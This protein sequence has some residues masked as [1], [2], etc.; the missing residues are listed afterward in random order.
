MLFRSGLGAIE[1]VAREF[2]DRSGLRWIGGCA[3]AIGFIGLC[4][5]WPVAAAVTASP[6]VSIGVI[7]GVVLVVGWPLMAIGKRL[8]TVAARLCLYSGGLARIDRRAA[9]PVVLRWADVETV[10]IETGDDEGTPTTYLTGCTLRGWSGVEIKVRREIR[11]QVVI[12]AHRT[13]APRVV[14]AMIRAY[15]SGQP[16]VPSV[17][18]QVSQWGIT[19][20]RRKRLPWTDIG[21]VVMEHHSATPG[22]TT[23]MDLR[24]GRKGWPHHYCDPSGVPNG[25]FLPDL[26]AHAARQ[27][28]VLVEGYAR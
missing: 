10:T 8:A 28:G 1:A 19:F 12:A 23:R 25:I 11:E 5:V 24:K 16:V 2:D 15:D 13:L 26:I 18:A 22:I 9:E 14:A 4:V 17:N 20:P 27:R 7:F 21:V 3:V 6:S